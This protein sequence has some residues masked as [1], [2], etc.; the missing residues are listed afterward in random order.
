[1]EGY[2]GP[3]QRSRYLE[4]R[5]SGCGIA[6]R[7]RSYDTATSAQEAD[8]A[9]RAPDALPRLSGNA[10]LPIQARP[11]DTASPD[12]HHRGKP[13]LGIPPMSETDVEFSGERSCN[14]ANDQLP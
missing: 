10:G 8:L 6:Q 2:G 7:G 11:P 5:W 13:T 12:K 9:A 3:A 4:I 1:M 14:D